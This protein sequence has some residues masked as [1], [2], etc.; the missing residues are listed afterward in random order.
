MNRPL[1]RRLFAPPVREQLEQE[2][3]LHRELLVDEYRARGLGEAEA[4]AEA[5]RRMGDLPRARADAIAIGEAHASRERHSDRWGNVRQDL[6]FAY[7]SLLRRKGWTTV[8]LLTLA[9][10]IG[11]STAV[12]SVVNSLLL[13]P[14]P[15]PGA[16]RIVLLFESPNN[17]DGMD[18][19]VGPFAEAIAAWRGHAKSF[20]AIE[21]FTSTDMTRIDRGAVAVVHATA[22]T[23][24][25]LGFAGEHL[26]AGR[27]FTAAD[28]LPGAERVVML[29]AGTWK[30][31][32]AAD[33]GVAGQ[34]VTL[35]GN[36]YTVIGVMPQALQVPGPGPVAPDFWLPFSPAHDATVSAIGR[37]APAATFAAAQR[38]LDTLAARAGAPTAKEFNARLSRPAEMVSFRS[39]LLLLSGAVALVLLIACGNV[40]HLLLARGA[41]RQREFAIRVALG[42]G[43]GRL[44]RQLVTEALALSSAGCIAGLTLGWL[45]LRLLVATRPDGLAELDAARVNGVV[46]LAAVGVS[47]ATGLVFGLT[48]MLQAS[49]H[50]PQSALKAGSGASGGGRRH[51][52]FR[53]VL[54]VT[55][56]AM[57]ATLLVGAT[58]LIRSVIRLQGN[59]LGFDTTGLYAVQVSAPGSPPDVSANLT[60]SLLERIRTVPG[61]TAVTLAQNPSPNIGVMFGTVEAEGQP[62]TKGDPYVSYNAVR[63]DHFRFMRIRLLEG[64]TFTDTASA[65]GQ[66]V[67]NRGF[68]HRYWPS[69]PVVGRRFRI[70]PRQPWQT[71]VGVTADVLVRGST[72]D[73]A[74]PMLYVPSINASHSTVLVRARPGVNP[75]PAIRTLVSALDPRLPP[76]RLFSVADEMARVLARPRFTMLLLTA[77]SVIAIILASVGL[78]GVLAHAVTQRTREIG[79]RV[80]LGATRANVI[81]AVVMNGIGLAAAGALV[82]LIVAHW[83]TRALEHLLYGVPRGDPLSFVAGVAI[84]LVTAA[85]ASVIPA[86]RAIAIDPMTAIRSD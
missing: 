40:A 38:E 20:E 62:A 71:V 32:F 1:F 45:G 2:L 6:R 4:D 10:G 51:Q 14:L 34:R 9:L 48:G 8:A 69:G 39:S 28:A 26:V 31:D 24:D 76:P 74:M 66:V 29:S 16:S 67:I 37:L 59:D 33:P 12:F 25:F 84:L 86:R 73:A 19:T 54:V 65:A 55:E 46:M 44:L 77:F 17:T 53:A 7:R 42:A 36:P 22:I 57:A 60:A 75:M 30:R 13:H 81:R 11:A 61:V 68:A 23:P 15:Y 80:A 70:S 18:I 85:L 41:S 63:A 5:D 21:P 64:T 43:R 72:G 79:I 82:G 56:M 47:L 52:R 35:D 49:L 50:G 78:Y 58:L 83:A 3:E 27:N